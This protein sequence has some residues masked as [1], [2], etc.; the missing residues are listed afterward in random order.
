MIK[1]HRQFLLSSV[2]LTCLLASSLPADEGWHEGDRMPALDQFGFGAGLPELKGKVVYLDF[3]ASWCA[4]CKASFPAINGWYQQLSGRGFVVLGVSVDDR[5][6]DMEAF[7]KKNLVSF[8][9][10]RDAS[11]NL[12]AA[13][14]VGTMPTSFLIDRNGFIR[15]VHSGFHKRDEAALLA[16]INALL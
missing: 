4:P 1:T 12:V 8:P 16:Q 5:A 3:W 10:V 15:H 7:L 13:A 14:N 9:V 2:A 6:S 11:H